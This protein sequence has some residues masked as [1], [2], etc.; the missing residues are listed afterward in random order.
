MRSSQENYFGKTCREFSQRATMLSVAS[1]LDLSA[2]MRPSHQQ[3]NGAVRVWL[4]DPRDQRRGACWMPNISSWPNDANVCSLSSVL[5][6]API[7]Q[8][9]YLSL[10]ACAGIIR[11]A[12]KRGRQLPEQLAHAL[13][14]V[15]GL[16][17]T[18]TSGGGLSRSLRARTNASHREDSET[19]IPEQS[20]CLNGGGQRRIDVESE[21][22]ITGP[23]QAGGMKA[24]GSA[25]QQ[26]AERGMLIAHSLRADGFDASEDGTGRGTP[27]VTV[28]NAREVGVYCCGDCG[29]EYA[30]LGSTDP[31]SPRVQLDGFMLLA[32]PCPRCGG[33]ADT[34]SYPT[35]SFGA[36]AEGPGIAESLRSHPR[37]GSNSLG[38]MPEAADVASLRYASGG[39][40]RSY[41]Q[42]MAVRRLIP[43][44]CEKLQGY[45]LGYTQVPFRGKPAADGPRYKALGNSMAVPVLSWILGRCR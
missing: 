15:A 6:T 10:K 12:E 11:R 3:Q 21:T 35:G 26:D 25:T 37:P 34:V 22:F 40:S 27:L 44:E 19:Y 33:N 2:L 42:Q 8:K 38:A 14:A 18:S 24:A 13:K 45:Q 9:Y 17:Q 32:N 31:S 7:P 5:E 23:L 30:A 4:L 43:E 28:S 29:A 1:W 20:M 39:S 41:V 16:E 36:D